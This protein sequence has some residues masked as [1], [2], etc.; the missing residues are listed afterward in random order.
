[1][2][3][4]PSPPHYG[5]LS[6]GMAQRIN[7]KAV[8]SQNKKSLVIKKQRMMDS[9][10]GA[11]SFSP[12]YKSVCVCVRVCPQNPGHKRLPSGISAK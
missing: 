12:R 2:T 8:V 4:P 5:Y 9:I 6:N 10:I 11:V 3:P 7:R 1:M